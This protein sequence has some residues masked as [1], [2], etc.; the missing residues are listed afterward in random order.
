MFQSM[1]KKAP[2]HKKRKARHMKR[3]PKKI[4]ANC[5]DVHVLFR[6]ISSPLFMT[7]RFLSG[8][9]TQRKEEEYIKVTKFWSASHITGGPSSLH[10]R[11]RDSCLCLRAV[12]CYKRLFTKACMGCKRFFLKE[13]K[14][15]MFVN[16]ID[17]PYCLVVFF[18]GCPRLRP[19]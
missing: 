7:H 10:E 15:V 1:S 8:S 19:F 6:F 9:C 18:V 11:G 13:R 17:L 2:K 5:G 14:N 3:L 4:P 16:K 12:L